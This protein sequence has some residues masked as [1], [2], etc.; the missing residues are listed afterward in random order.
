[1]TKAWKVVRT[2]RELE[3]PGVD[4]RL[5]ES[6]VELV[7]LA[8]D[9][10]EEELILA[11]ADA[12]LLLTCY[13]KITR[14]VIEGASNLKAIVKYGVGID[15]ID[16]D[17]A[18]ERSIP[19]ANVPGYAE[20]TV[21]EGA[22]VLMMALAKRFKLI[23][24]AM[25][26]DG[27]VWPENRW[28]ANDLAGKTLGLIGVGRIGRSMARMASAFR[29][30]VLG[31]DPHVVDMP[32]ERYTDLTAM[33]E[34]CD[35][36]SLHCVLNEQTRKIL[37]DKELRCMKQTAYLVNVSRGELIDEDALLCALCEKRLAGAALDVYEDEPLRKL[38]HRLSDLYSMDNVILWPHLTFYTEEAMQRLEYETLQR[39]FEALEGRLLTITSGDPRLIAQTAGV[40]FDLA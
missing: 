4:R 35:F 40:R 19:V 1:M 2:D 30:Q 17:A 27:W 20:E 38:G 37:G 22:F 5:R 12:D 21:A 14:K 29:M 18:R 31:F 34:Q 39:C 8:G 33:L 23:H 15:A 9:V 6:G 25:Q 10:S 16:I 36:V 13:A 28:I 24:H 11:I 32:A 3:L 7:L 26:T